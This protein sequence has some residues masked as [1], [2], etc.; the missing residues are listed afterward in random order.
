[1]SEICYDC[2]NPLDKENKTVEHVPAKNLY[3]GFGEEFKRNRITVPACIKCNQKYSKVDQEIR[4]VL[5]IQNDKLDEK[6]ELTAKGIRSI[7][8][9]SNWKERV[10]T[11]E[12]GEVI[13]LDF[14]YDELKQI[15]VKN[16]KALFYVKYGFPVPNNFEIE[17]ITDGDDHLT[18][19]A[20]FFY[21]YL[22][23]DQEWRA[24]G[25]EDI[26]KYILKGIS[27]NEANN[28]IEDSKDFEKLLGVAGILVYHDSIAAVV[29][30]GRKDYLEGIK[31]TI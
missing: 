25:H 10:Y 8:R 13:A 27:I 23:I 18:K 21:D 31:K 22:T 24:S 3:E 29:V 17:I 9:R 14:N 19:Q 15:H 7:L 2:S 6:K 4:D 16:F 26:F 1:M 12:K 20:Q 28:I 5:A 30:A 11:N